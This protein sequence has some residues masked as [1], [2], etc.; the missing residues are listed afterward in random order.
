[1]LPRHQAMLSAASG[2]LPVSSSALNDLQDFRTAYPQWETALGWVPFAA[3][4]P[5][6]GSWTIVQNILEDAAWQILQPFTTLE[7]IPPLLEQLD[8][9]IPEVLSASQRD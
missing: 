4:P 2:Y 9:M 7:G 8:A 5:I 6:T 1:M 3:S